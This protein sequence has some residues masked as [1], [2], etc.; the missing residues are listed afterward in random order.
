MNRDYLT[1][2]NFESLSPERRKLFLDS[3]FAE[4]LGDQY[5][6]ERLRYSSRKDPQGATLPGEYP[7]D[8]IIRLKKAVDREFGNSHSAYFV[9]AIK[10]MKTSNRRKDFLNPGYLPLE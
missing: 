1:L 7:V 2:K 3:I 5:P 6:M 9:P 4:A 10:G 8:W